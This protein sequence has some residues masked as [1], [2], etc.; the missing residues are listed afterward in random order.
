[1]NVYTPYYIHVFTVAL[2]RETQRERE[3]LDHL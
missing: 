2:G 1:M 3:S